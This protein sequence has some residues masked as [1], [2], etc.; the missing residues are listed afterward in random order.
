V[1]REMT[2]VR[3][4]VLNKVWRG[5]DPF[6]N[7]P[8]R[9]YRSDSQGWGSTH[10]YLAEAIETIRPSVIVE[11][12]VWKGGSIITLASKMKE[13]NLDG[14]VIA[15][16]T[17]LG[18]WDHWTSD[19]WFDHLNFNNGYPSLY[20]TFATNVIEAGLQDYV[21]PIPLDSTNAANVLRH[22]GIGPDVVH[23][24]AGHDRNAVTS[25]LREWWP[26]IR[27]GG[28]LI[29]DDYPD[30]PGVKAAFD[31]FFSGLDRVPLEFEA[32]KCRVFK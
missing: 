31:D 16:D 22:H 27:P 15:I 2:K 14:V 17:W 5:Q 20:H 30:W 10:R 7:Y 21:L 1:G 11:I 9:L 13:M 8:G 23:I 19:E 24:D 29:G 32:P 25:D 6:Q 28:V 4:S 26:M 18:A 12:G 3:D